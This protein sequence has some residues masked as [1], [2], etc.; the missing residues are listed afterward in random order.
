VL[1]PSTEAYDR[2][3]KFEHYSSVESLAEY[4]LIASDRIRV[5]LYARQPGGKWLLS[6][7]NRLEDM[8]S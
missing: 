3:R 2:G 8:L 7:A 5:D 4:L 1:S 6:A